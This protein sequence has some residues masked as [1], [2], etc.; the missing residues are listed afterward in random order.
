MLNGTLSEMPRY[1]GEMPRIGLVIDGQTLG[2]LLDNDLQAQFLQLCQHSHSVLCCRATPLQK[3]KVV[4]LLR[5]RLKVMTL[6]IGNTRP[7]Y[8]GC[9][10]SDLHCSTCRFVGMPLLFLNMK[11]YF[12]LLLQVMVPMT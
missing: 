3:G 8:M 11:T 7:F 4:T 6:A 1:Q 9:Q 10:V 12:G 2:M 5:D